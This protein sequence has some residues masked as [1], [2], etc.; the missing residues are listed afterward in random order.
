MMTFLL[1]PAHLDAVRAAELDGVLDGFRTGGQQKDL[2]QRFWQDVTQLFHKPQT[3]LVG[4][5]VAGEQ[6]MLDLGVDGRLD[7][8]GWQWPALV[9]STPDDQSTH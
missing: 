3:R 6:T 2:L 9:M 1:A 5:A 8:W 4:E 7:L